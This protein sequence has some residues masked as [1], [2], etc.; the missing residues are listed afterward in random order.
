MLELIMKKGL[1]ILLV[2]CLFY[3]SQVTSIMAKTNIT[4]WTSQTQSERMKTIQLL[5]DTF[6]ALNDDI[7]VNLVAIEEND[8]P[9]QMAAASAAGN[10]PEVIEM[11]SELAVAFGSEGIMDFRAHESLINQIGRNDFFEG[12]LQLT[13]SPDGKAYALPYHGWIQGI[14]YRADWFEKAGLA[15]PTTWYNILKAAKYF[16]NPSKNMYG[17]LIGTKPEGFTEQVFTQ[18]AISNGAR[19]FDADGKLIFNSDEMLETLNFYKELQ[20]YN[21]PGPHTWRARD[22]YLQGKMAMFFYSTYIMDDLSLADV[23]KGS[24]TGDNFE[25][26][27]GSTFDSNLVKN[28]K[29]VSSFKNTHES[30]YGVIVSLGI[31]K[32]DDSSK[33]EAAKKLVRFLYEED[34]YVSFLHMAPGGMN[35][36]LRSM[37]KSDKFMRDPKGIFKH[38]GKEKI[39]Q[40]IGGLDHLQK[41]EIVEGKMFPASGEIFAQKII[42]QMVYKTIFEGVSSEKA[43]NEAEANM[44]KI[45]NK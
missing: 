33:T 21:P 18:F 36:V 37:A 22:Y 28:T 44:R 2:S 15:P 43:M 9:T 27:D 32:S 8:Q 5:M 29:M 7:K 6:E 20:K 12:A 42:P 19:Q 23:A 4:F 14:W 11:G 10:I 26:L 13:T 41:F 34:S 35:P 17:I 25:G 38:Y 39:S 30:S 31:T 45:I 16:N 40:I 3:I 1:V 24:L